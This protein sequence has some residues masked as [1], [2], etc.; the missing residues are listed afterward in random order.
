MKPHVADFVN[1]IRNI[2]FTFCFG[3]RRSRLS[4]K[5][6]RSATSLEQ[7]VLRS[8]GKNLPDH[9]D[10]ATGQARKLNTDPW[11]SPQV[12]ATTASWAATPSP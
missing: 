3:V 1:P 8:P 2:Y 6:L 9:Q 4:P 11:A 7:R 10:R 5:S 12:L